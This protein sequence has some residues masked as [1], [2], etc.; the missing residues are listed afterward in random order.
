[1][2]YHV[3][4]LKQ[5]QHDREVKVGYPLLVPLSCLLLTNLAQA[6]ALISEIAGS[7]SRLPASSKF[8]EISVL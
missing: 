5:V 7:R 3:Q 2:A 4:M 1:M 8:I 6:S